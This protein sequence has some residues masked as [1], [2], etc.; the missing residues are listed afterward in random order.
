[1]LEYKEHF[2]KEFNL[3]G[4][5][6]EVGF[7]S[8]SINELI[9]F[10]AYNRNIIKHFVFKKQLDD[11]MNVVLFDNI[12]IRNF[13]T[14]MFENECERSGLVEDDKVN[15]FYKRWRKWKMV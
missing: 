10:V 7:V 12:L 11:Y 13:E 3:L 14:F 15:C 2:P 1:M 8:E 6:Y 5:L 9:V 4:K